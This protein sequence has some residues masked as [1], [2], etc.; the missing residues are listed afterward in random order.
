MGRPPGTR[1][2]HE[3]RP[4]AP[5]RRNHDPEEDQAY[6]LIECQVTPDMTN[7]G[8]DPLRRLLQEGFQMDPTY[9]NPSDQFYQVRMPMADYKAKIAENTRLYKERRDGPE[10]SIT[11]PNV[12]I[13][14]IKDK[15]D[16]LD[17]EVKAAMDQLASGG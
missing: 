13:K 12:S 16:H 4:P 9:S 5:T 7:S 10:E 3:E 1:T 15:R 11:T 6:K 2:L 17:P 14:Q 8:R